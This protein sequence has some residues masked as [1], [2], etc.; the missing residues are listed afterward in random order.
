MVAAGPIILAS[1]S[2]AR[3]KMLTA[4]GVSFTVQPAEL[5]E[6]ALRSEILS[7][8]SEIDPEYIAVRLACEK[9]RSVSRLN[10]GA[11]VIGADQVLNFQGHTIEKSRGV[12]EARELLQTLRGQWHSLVSAFSLARNGHTLCFHADEAHM[13]MR[14]VS[15]SFLD[16]YLARAGESIL[17]CVGCYEIEGL[18]AQLFDQVVGDYFT[19]LGMPLIPLLAELRKRGAIGS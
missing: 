5:D 1:G 2:S 8:D 12:S 14:D 4:A 17:A 9:A 18:G 15:D 3:R 10:P 11:I 16:A 19:I 7:G 6:V 13:F